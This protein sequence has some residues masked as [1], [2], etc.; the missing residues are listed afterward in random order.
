MAG[1][2][3]GETAIAKVAL[4]AA[5]ILKISLGDTI[6]W[7]AVTFL[8][9]GM[10]KLGTQPFTTS[11]AQVNGWTADAATYPGS[12]VSNNA[13]VAQGAKAGATIAASITYGNSYT[14]FNR[15]IRLKLNGTVIATSP[16]SAAYSGTL[17]ASATRDV[18]AGDKVTV[19]VMVELYADGL[20][21]AGGTVT[22]T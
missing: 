19:E 2:S 22:I 5:E 16:A 12:T 13:L 3:I 4:G 7:Q 15:Y 11:W 21:N 8:P 17:T 1:I 18:A 10:T 14:S 6:V 20:I 9:S